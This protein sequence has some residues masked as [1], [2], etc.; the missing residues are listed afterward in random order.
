MSLSEEESIP[1]RIQRRLDELERRSP[2]THEE[3]FTQEVINALR[4]SLARIEGKL[5][6]ALTLRRDFEAYRSRSD[7][8]LEDVRTRLTK[9]EGWQAA[10][11]WIA[12]GVW[13]VSMIILT[14]VLTYLFQ[15]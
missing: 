5:D 1:V 10:A 6:A 4:V 3:A 11:H 7:D 15:H 12:G 8:E 14:I 9:A 2:T 13:S